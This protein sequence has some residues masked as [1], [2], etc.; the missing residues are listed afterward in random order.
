MSFGE[1][2]EYAS[3]HGIDKPSQESGMNILTETRSY[4]RFQC[5]VNMD[6]G[7]VKKAEYKFLD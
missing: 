2:S 4:G 7:V 1:L 3:E 5:W 6:G